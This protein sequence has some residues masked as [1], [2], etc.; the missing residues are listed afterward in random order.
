MADGL[1]VRPFSDFYQERDGHWIWAGGMGGRP[2]VPYWRGGPARRWAMEANGVKVD[3]FRVFRNCDEDSCVNPAH[4]SLRPLLAASDAVEC[5]TCGLSVGPN[6]RLEKRFECRSCDNARWRQSRNA[7]ARRRNGELKKAALEQYG[8]KCACCGEGHEVFL[9]IDHV[10]DNGAEH[11]RSMT[12]ASVYRWL[13][14]AGYPQE[15]FQVLCFNCNWAKSHGGC[16]HGAAAGQP[17]D[18]A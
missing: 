9:T 17:R 7:S 4:H 11:R 16:P 18:E 14:N 15:G 8:G 12:E 1:R 3:G 13:K 10:S 6:D 5:P 2:P